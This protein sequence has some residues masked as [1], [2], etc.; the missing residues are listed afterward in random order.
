MSGRLEGKVALVT[1]SA[2]GLGAATAARFAAEGA[3]VVGLDLNESPAAKE[4]HVASV[5]DEDAVAGVVRSIV[6]AYGRLDVVANFAAPPAA[7][8]CTGSTGPSGTA[9][10]R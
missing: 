7:G 3:T 10:S 1:G 5:T 6:D 4:S 2:S 9:S 8:R